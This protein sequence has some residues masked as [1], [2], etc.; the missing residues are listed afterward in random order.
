MMN[1]IRVTYDLFTR[2]WREANADRL[3]MITPDEAQRLMDYHWTLLLA[4]RLDEE[5]DRLLARAK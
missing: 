3:R 4:T 2:Y 5:T 1:E